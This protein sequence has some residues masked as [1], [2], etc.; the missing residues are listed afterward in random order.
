MDLFKY[1]F[2]YKKHHVK[3]N[4]VAY[5]VDFKNFCAADSLT[6]GTAKFGDVKYSNNFDI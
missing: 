1:L 6:G 4:K 5:R 3:K 2:I